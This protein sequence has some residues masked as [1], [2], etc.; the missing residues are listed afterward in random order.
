MSVMDHFLHVHCCD[1]SARGVINHGG[2]VMREQ[3]RVDFV[4]VQ[5]GKQKV[6]C[7]HSTVA[8]ELVETSNF[9]FI[10][11]KISLGY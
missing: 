8:E 4:I 2:Q 10:I 11:N 1:S 3:N 7:H 5:C 6:R 9:V